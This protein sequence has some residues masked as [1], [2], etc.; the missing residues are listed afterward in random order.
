MLP[1]RRTVSHLRRERCT[2]FR[3][4]LHFIVITVT[5]VTLPM[6]KGFLRDDPLLRSAI[7]R[8]IYRPIVTE[9]S[10]SLCGS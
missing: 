2:A 5:V 8:H 7:Y 1:A 4:P 10:P 6:S 3:E 9:K